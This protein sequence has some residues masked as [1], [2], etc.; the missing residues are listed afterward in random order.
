[1][2]VKQDGWPGIMRIGIVDIS[3]FDFC[4]AGSRFIDGAAQFLFQ[5]IDLIGDAAIV[6]IITRT[7]IIPVIPGVEMLLMMEDRTVVAEGSGADANEQN[8]QQQREE[9]DAFHK[10]KVYKVK[11]YAGRK[12]KGG[13]CSVNIV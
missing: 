13:E 12:G 11:K 5:L 7:G 6:D 9:R 2:L 10:K 8:G 4:A 3:V 1:M